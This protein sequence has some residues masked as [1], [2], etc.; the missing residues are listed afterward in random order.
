MSEKRPDLAGHSI[1]AIQI[2]RWKRAM[3][4]AYFSDARFTYLPL[5]LG[6]RDFLSVWSSALLQADRPALLVWGGDLPQEMA[7]FAEANGI[8]VYFLEDG[9]IRSL[10]GSASKALPFSLTLDHRAAYFDA[11]RPSDLED[12]LATYDFDADPALRRRAE[13]GIAA[14]SGVGVPKTVSQRC[15]RRG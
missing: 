3:L 8:P 13:D 1:F 12:L 5:Y 4:E 14:Q 7:T 6:G 2:R 15:L 11:R 10:V 9:F